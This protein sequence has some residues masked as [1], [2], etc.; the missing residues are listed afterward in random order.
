M[1]ARSHRRGA[2]PQFR[3]LE[4]RRTCLRFRRGTVDIAG[5]NRSEPSVASCFRIP[6]DPCTRSAC[7]MPVCSASDRRTCV[8]PISPARLS[9]LTIAL[10]VR[11][12]RAVICVA[13][14]TADVDFD[15]EGHS[16][17]GSNVPGTIQWHVDDP[18]LGSDELNGPAESHGS[19]D[20]GGNKS[21]VEVFPQRRS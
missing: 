4:L 3:T 17:S 10:R 20:S 9:A 7:L 6:D 2:A 14:L 8:K 13:A 12:P 5:G 21:R 19:L 11:L 16:A 1:V 18:A 15:F